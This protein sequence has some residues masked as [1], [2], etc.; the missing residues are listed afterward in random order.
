[1]TRRQAATL[2]LLAPLSALGGCEWLRNVTQPDK[3]TTKADGPVQ[4]KTREELVTYLNRESEKLNSVSSKK[5][6]IDITGQQTAS[7]SDSSLICQKPMNFALVGGKKLLG[8]I[9]KV[10]SNS[11]EFWV[12][13]TLSD[14][15]YIYCSHAD[16][17]RG[18]AQL[19]FPFDT[20]WALQALGMSHYDPNVPYRVDTDQATREHRLRYESTTPQGATVLHVVVFAADDMGDKSPQVRQ[21]LVTDAAGKPIATASIKS[22]ATLAAGRSKTDD[23]EAFVQVPTEV[24][25]DW[26]QQQF[27]MRLQLRSPK[28]NEPISDADARELFNRPTI[29]GVTPVNLTS[30]Q[31]T[32]NY[33][34]ATPDGL[35][36]RKPRGR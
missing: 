3:R 21:H 25:L 23:K 36:V 26:P 35:P 12:I 13:N 11:R 4:P 1:M 7:L 2:A 15:R 29:S 18:T 31:S 16:F 8:D 14:P 17:Q 22:V 27:R 20:E 19:P 28:I 10:G 6:L 30:L 32:P 5:V 24:V 33:R 9:V 34:G